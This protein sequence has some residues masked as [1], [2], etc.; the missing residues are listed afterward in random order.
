MAISI[1]R[2]AS[3]K[4]VIDWWV[5]LG[6]E[7]VR[8]HRTGEAKYTHPKL[9]GFMVRGSD[10]RKDAPLRLVHQLK[11][12]AARLAAPEQSGRGI[13][14]E[15]APLKPPVVAPASRQETPPLAKEA[16]MSQNDPFM[17]IETITPEMAARWLSEMPTNRPLRKRRVNTYARAMLTD[18]W[19]VNGESIKFN[20]AGKVIDGQHR[21][22]ACVL[23]KKPFKSY[24]IHNVAEG[25]EITIDTGI[26]RTFHDAGT[27]AG[28]HFSRQLAPILRYWYMYE[29]QAFMSSKQAPTHQELEAIRLAHPNATR[30]CDFIGKSKT[31]KAAAPPAVLGFVHSYISEKYD[32]DMADTFIQDLNDGADLKR[33]NPIYHLRKQLLENQIKGRRFDS[34]HVLA[35]CIKAWNAWFDGV[36]LMQL[37]YID[38][39]DF[40]RFGITS[41]DAQRQRKVRA[42]KR[43]Q[44]GAA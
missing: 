23:A 36:E 15:T 26:G 34:L 38:G 25:A 7:V 44:E 39:E 43:A 9:V 4:D 5:G 32:S 21:L 28:Y 2:G 22:S 3:R 35:L 16:K 1:E 8:M 42:A 20:K 40:P 10:H 19:Q 29:C 27:I 24:V 37:K 17:R 11:K 12:A 30:S 14:E 6:G 18:L 13:P 33:T 31:I 41:K